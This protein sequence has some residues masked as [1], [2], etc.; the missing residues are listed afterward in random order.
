[1]L[2]SNGANGDGVAAREA[3]VSEK[4]SHLSRFGV[5]YP[6]GAARASSSVVCISMHKTLFEL[7]AAYAPLYSSIAST[8]I[9]GEP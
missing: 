2:M 5:A 7:G 8:V 9:T 3:G 6:G 1:M 4:S